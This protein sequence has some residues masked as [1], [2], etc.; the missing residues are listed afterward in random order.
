[1]FDR[2]S[3]CSIRTMCGVVCLWLGLFLIQMPYTLAVTDQT[4]VGVP[5]K[6]S[7]SGPNCTNVRTLFE[8]RGINSNDV[9][10][11]P[12]NGKLYCLKIFTRFTNAFLGLKL[13]EL[14]YSFG[15]N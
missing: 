2:R 10:S 11:E 4:K 5:Q 14:L 7:G 9:P 15:R 1:M 8:S 6:H 13:F 3:V 12:I